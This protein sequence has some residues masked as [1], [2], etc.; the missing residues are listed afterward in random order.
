[1]RGV[2]KCN[3]LRQLERGDR[4]MTG[5]LQP[6]PVTDQSFSGLAYIARQVCR[7]RTGNAGGS[8]EI[9]DQDDVAA[10]AASSQRQLPAV[11]RPVK[12]ENQSRFKI[13][14][15]FRRSAS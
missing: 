2:N 9:T 12:V 15:L 7:W 8:P 14:D 6:H 13:R 1:V 4:Y 5:K 11:T 10:L 3:C